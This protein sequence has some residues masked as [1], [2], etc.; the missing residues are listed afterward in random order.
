MVQLQGSRKATRDKLLDAVAALRSS[1]LSVSSVG[2]NILT[3]IEDRA[4]KYGYIEG[5]YLI[6]AG[7]GIN[8]IETYLEEVIEACTEGAKAIAEHG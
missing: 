6:E 7:N 3:P 1:L 8:L 4:K 2:N 5:D